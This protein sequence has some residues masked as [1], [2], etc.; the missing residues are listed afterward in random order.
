MAVPLDQI[1]ASV[2]KSWAAL[3]DDPIETRGWG[4]VVL[5]GV[6]GAVCVAVVACRLWL[7]G[8]V[9]RQADLS[10]WFTLL[11]LVSASLS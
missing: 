1:P 6:L 4:I 5:S 11:A 8:V 2:L 7:R 10:D 9:Q 3:A